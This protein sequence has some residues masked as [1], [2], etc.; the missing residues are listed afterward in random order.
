MLVT[1]FIRYFYSLF[2]SPNSS[3]STPMGTPKV[4]LQGGGGRRTRGCNGVWR[5]LSN[6]SSLGQVFTS[7]RVLRKY[8]KC[9][10]SC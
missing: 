6:Q 2:I 1:I 9:K 8:G 7:R 4:D 5:L 3:H 10:I